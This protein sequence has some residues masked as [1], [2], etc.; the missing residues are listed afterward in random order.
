MQGKVTPIA[1]KR[2]ERGFWAWV[3]VVLEWV[4][5]GWIMLHLSLIEDGSLLHF[6][7]VLCGIYAHWRYKSYLA[8]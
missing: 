8:S 1:E 4:I 7:A 6:G 5:I 3:A 2:K